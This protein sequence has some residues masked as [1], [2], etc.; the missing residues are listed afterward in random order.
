MKITITPEAQERLRQHQSTETKGDFVLVYDSDGCGCAVSGV[1]QLWL[2]HPLDEEDKPADSRGIDI[3]YKPRQAVFFDE[4]M[5]IDYNA[6]LKSFKLSSNGQI[7]NA[8][9][10][11][12]DKRN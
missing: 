5:T 8:R 4:Q 10:N 6:A 3:Y 2:V 9:M 12:I 7:F 11:V 1:A